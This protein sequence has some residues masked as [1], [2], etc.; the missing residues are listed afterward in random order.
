MKRIIEKHRY[1]LN[2]RVTCVNCGSV[3]SYES[4]DVIDD[5]DSKKSIVICPVCEK[6]IPVPAFEEKELGTFSR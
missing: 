3:F 2:P 6:E 5:W 1:D 4:V